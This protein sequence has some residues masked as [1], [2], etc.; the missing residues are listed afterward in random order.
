MVVLG[1]EE[2]KESLEILRILIEGGAD[3]N[4]IFNDGPTSLNLAIEFNN[5][6]LVTELVRGGANVNLKDGRS[7]SPLAKAHGQ[8]KVIDFLRS[9]GTDCKRRCRRYYKS[10]F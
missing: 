6:E 4:R 2:G 10:S 5:L 1:D 7:M 9:P 3:P 8:P